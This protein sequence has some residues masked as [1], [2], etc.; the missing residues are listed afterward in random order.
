MIA[1]GVVRRLQYGHAWPMTAV[2]TLRDL[3]R[4]AA[5]VL[6]GVVSFVIALSMLS[7]AGLAGHTYRYCTA[8]RAVMTHACC[9][10]RALQDSAG[11]ALSEHASVAPDCCQTRSFGTL[12]AYTRADRTS[13]PSV[14]AQLAL[15]LP[16]R[17]VALPPR[18]PTSWS[19]GHAGAT[20]RAGPAKL[21][22]H[23][24]LMVFHV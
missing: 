11:R 22:M 17:F 16:V 5:G 9:P 13:E 4:A 19:Y 1:I 10:G 2:S 23:A 6:R 24:L 21:R 12:D 15:A 14:S 18:E 7:G 20:P 3:S 8:M